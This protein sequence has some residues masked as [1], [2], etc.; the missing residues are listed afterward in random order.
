MPAAR[1]WPLCTVTLSPASSQT[2]T[3]DFATADGTAT[4]GADYAAESGT[5]SF[6]AGETS[7]TIAVEVLPDTADEPD[8]TLFVDLS[9]AVGATISD[10][11]GTGTILDDDPTTSH[12]LTVTVTGNGVVTSS[13]GGINCAA[14]TS[15][16]CSQSY[17]AG[18]ATVV[19][20]SARA[21]QGW[22]FARWS[23]DCSVL[24]GT[25]CRVKMTADRSVTATFTK[26][27]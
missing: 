27:P 5:V 18:D 3:V 2:V 4:A 24:K 6:A 10:G 12:T 21:R 19:T 11:R 20:L 13:P 9:N 25:R 23:G 15:S 1:A 8:E 14:K 22:V 26:S 16:D 17:P 7:T